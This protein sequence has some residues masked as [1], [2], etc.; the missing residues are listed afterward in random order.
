MVNSRRKPR[1]VWWPGRL[2]ETPPVAQHS[3]SSCLRS[4]FHSSDSKGGS[5]DSGPTS[6]THP[7]RPLFVMNQ[8]LRG[9]LLLRSVNPDTPRHQLSHW[10]GHTHTASSEKQMNKRL[11]IQGFY[12]DRDAHLDVRRQVYVPHQV[13]QPPPPWITYTSMWRHSPILCNF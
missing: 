1:R 12:D 7:P 6:C 10:S 4:C 9:T 5:A 3:S 13:V 2:S 11:L 8:E